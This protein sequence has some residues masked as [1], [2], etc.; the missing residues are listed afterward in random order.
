[1]K[2]AVYY[3]RIVLIILMFYLQWGRREGENM[4]GN[5]NF[6]GLTI[7]IIRGITIPV[8]L[9]FLVAGLLIFSAVKRQ[10]DSQSETE[11]MVKSQAA[12]NQI[13]EFFTSY[14]SEAEQI[15]SNRAYEE[16]IIKASKSNRIENLPEFESVRK[17]LVKS[18]KTDTENILAV[19]FGGFEE[20]QIIQSDGYISPDDWDIT[21][22]PWYKVKETKSVCLTPPYID[23]STGE[24]IITAAAPVINEETGEII[25]AAGIDIALAQIETIMNQYELGETGSFILSDSQGTIVHNKNADY[26]NKNIDEIG[27][28]S[29]IVQAIQNNNTIFTKYTMDGENEYG[30]VSMVGNTNWNVTSMLPAKEFNQAVNNISFSVVVIFLIGIVI[31]VTVVR[32][33][34][35]SM[36]KPLRNLTQV[37]QK[38]AEGD[39]D[40]VVTAESNDEI[41]ALGNAIR[42]TVNRLKDYI[43]YIEE[44]SGVLGNIAEGNLRFE[45]KQEYVGEFAVLKDGLLQIQEKLTHTLRQIN[46]VSAQVADGSKQISQVATTLAMSS[47]EQSTSMEELDQSLQVVNDLSQNNKEN[48]DIAAQSAKTAGGFLENGNRKMEELTRTIEEIKQTSQKIDNIMQIIEDISSQTNL[49]S[50]N[51]SIEAAR[52]GESGRGFAVVANEVGSLASQT[53]GSSKETGD[54]IL[55]IQG[56]IDRGSEVAKETTHTMLDVLENAKDATERMVGISQSAQSEAQAIQNLLSKAERI[57]GA[58]ESNMAISEESVAASEELAHQAEELKR[59]VDEFQ[60]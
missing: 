45:L 1:M 36:V 41:G 42:N 12:A 50:L 56:A 43:V 58:V 7:K 35:T 4:K 3:G 40:V 21:K 28:S 60:I 20:S 39:L 5:K 19:W 44:I 22:R 55:A 18:A 14:L 6:S 29:N 37:A 25:G 49:L 33:I 26:I 31:I 47:T 51:A 30:C 9:V 2:Q 10:V 59:L 54:L 34:A 16:A 15:A 24:M 57:T 27:L 38:I 17:G 23:A 46:S 48:A 52:A 13:S 11:L 32:I 53:A 8:I